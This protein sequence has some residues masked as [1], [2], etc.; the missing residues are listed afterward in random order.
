MLEVS[1]RKN[2][3][4]EEWIPMVRLPMKEGREADFVAV[5]KTYKECGGSTE[6]CHTPGQT[7][8]LNMVRTHLS[9]LLKVSNK[10]YFVC[11]EILQEKTICAKKLHRLSLFQK[12]NAQK[13]TRGYLKHTLAI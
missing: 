11:L 10:L 5:I 7:F 6:P 1:S 9:N 13:Y 4:D 12:I 2:S 3:P 8:S